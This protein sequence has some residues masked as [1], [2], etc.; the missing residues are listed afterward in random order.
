MLPVLLR[1]YDDYFGPR[2]SLSLSPSISRAAI[3][4]S[5]ENMKSGD[6]LV[7]YLR[8]GVQGR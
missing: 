7:M 2:F 5:A 6:N 8:V 4:L 3:L 1:L